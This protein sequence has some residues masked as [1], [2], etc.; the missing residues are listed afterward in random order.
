VAE[1]WENV[2]LTAEE[3]DRIITI[4]GREPNDLE[5]GLY[6]LMWSE[7]CSY[8]HS[9]IHLALFPSAGEAVL[10]GPGENAG[11]LDIGNGLGLAFR[12]E[13]HNHP[14]AIEPYQ[15]A[16]T[17]IGGIVRDIFTMGARPIALLD[18]LRFGTLDEP[19]NRYL[20]SGVVSGISGYGNCLGLPTVGGEVYFD[21]CYRGNPLVNVLCLGLVPKDRIVR[22]QATG[23]GN[24]VFIVGARTG[25][26][27]I[28]GA[29]LLASREFDESAEEMRPAVQV[30]DPFM[31]KLLIEA[32]LELFETDFVVGMNDLGA[33]GL[34]SACSET[35]GRAGSGMELDVAL[36]PRREEGMN[37]YEVMLS[38][39]QERMLVI[40]RQ[41][42]ED[43][44]R[45]IFEK[46]GL[47]AAQIGRVT[48]DGLL[49]VR[50]NGRLVAEVPAAS[51]SDQAPVYDRPRRRP[52]Y[53][54][55]TSAFD[56][57]QIPVPEEYESWL[58]RLLQS[59][60]L[61]S[62]EWIF[63]QFDYMVRTNTIVYPGGDAAVLRIKGSE[64][65]VAVSTDGNA[66]YCYLDPHLGGAIAV[67]EAARNV[68]CTGARP[69]GITNCLNFGSPERP[70][71]LWQ[72][73]Q[74]IEGMSEA[75]RALG[76]PVTGGNVSFYNETSGQA[77]H[78]TPVVG[79][80]G[81]LDDI[82]KRCTAGFKGAGDVV[83]L[84]G[85]NR[86]ELG[87]SE[88]L[89]QRTGQ[90]TG[91][92][93][94]LDLDLERAV[95]ETCLAGISAGLIRSAHDCAEGGLAVA[96]AECCFLS[97]TDDLAPPQLPGRTPAV[98]VQV[99]LRSDM[100]PDALLFGESQSRILV[101]VKEE[102]VPQLEEIARSNG[103]PCTVLGMT[104]G[105]RLMITGG[106]TGQQL[107]DLPVTELW[108]SWQSALE[109]L[110]G[111]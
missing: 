49:R 106:P 101:T 96:L 4:L 40:V 42:C 47:E 19:R 21:S 89:V 14:S 94:R 37:P 2:G 100:R 63:G 104:G 65:G 76:T 97:S 85:S 90:V 31:E 73:R 7:H 16:A 88:Y 1:R 9:K 13:S 48:D 102:D 10:Q 83:V 103:A 56:I 38:E 95:Q 30:G 72:F 108:Q 46:W 23:V 105:E 80:V 36:V 82:S 69:A 59:P 98:G 62:K 27:G 5:L 74:V 45:Q 70:D 67:A 57:D 93:P 81:L 77:I 78:P 92:P 99:S 24:P 41:G 3:Y 28:H 61:A 22:G 52:D 68:V 60:N 17:G 64:R 29:S 12:L 71:V 51:L 111:E 35:A 54:D 43:Q 75:C 107:I 66:R 34:T 79:M 58:Q 39:S 91:R 33:A 6:G 84:L 18:S 86:P 53:L 20:C 15:G 32:C 109:K 26:D 55:E 8:K 11:V 50:E 44:V 110:L 87:G 25:R